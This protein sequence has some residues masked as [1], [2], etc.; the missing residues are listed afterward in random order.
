MTSPLHPIEDAARLSPH[1]LVTPGEMGQAD[2]LTIEAGTAELK[3]ME[4]AGRAV[5]DDIAARHPHGTRVAVVCGP[6]NNGGDGFVAARVLRE[7]G[8]IVRLLLLPGRGPEG[9]AGEMLKRAR[10]APEPPSRAAIDEAA[11]IVDALFGAGL[12]RPLDGAAAEVVG[13]INAA[14][15]A[16]AIVVAVD[17]PSGVDGRTGAVLGV[18][19][20]ATRSVTFFRR[21][22]GHLLLPGRLHTGRCLVHD[23]GI[24]D[25]V[26]RSIG[27]RAAAN[28]PSLWA[29]QWPLRRADAHKFSRGTVLVAG[30]D[31]AS[32][33]AAKLAA[34]AALRTGAGLVTIAVPPDA[35]ATASAYLAALIVRPAETADAF[36]ALVAEPRLKAIVVGPATGVGAATRAKTAAA[37]GTLAGVVLDADALSSHAADPDELFRQIASRAAPVV[38]T[39]HEGEFARL[40]PDL[41]PG[42][43]VSKIDRARAAAA[44]SGAVV[45][46]KGADTVIAAP[47]GFALVNENAPPDLATAGSGDVLAG[48]VAGLLAQ[49]RDGLTA[50][51]IGVWMHGR[52]GQ[53][54]GPGLVAD[55]LVG[56]LRTVLAEGVPVED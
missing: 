20:Q 55:D 38:L 27:P 54:A 34:A 51:A 43:G 9:S 1:V 56:A 53:V 22:P 36:A 13:W 3:L 11:V 29:A 48:I 17:L 52:A 24:R 7:R 19:V 25:G 40:F 15:A 6:G 37:L 47:D 33:G 39:P 49:G 32:T 18:A 35:V 14:E 46:L 45:I 50:A 10:L 8:L 16:G 4:R 42:E 2:R 23:I 26:L 5:A 28:H 21:K 31:A 41:A 44:R 30:G 12:A